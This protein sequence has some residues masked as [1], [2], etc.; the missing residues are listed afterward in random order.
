MLLHGVLNDHP[1][2]KY[3]ELETV[4]RVLSFFDAR[5]AFWSRRVFEPDS[6][7]YNV[8]PKF[9]ERFATFEKMIGWNGEAVKPVDSERFFGWYTS[10]VSGFVRP[11]PETTP[12]DV[13][14]A[15][16]QTSA[17]APTVSQLRLPNEMSWVV[18]ADR[19]V[20]LDRLVSLVEL[21]VNL[22]V[23]AKLLTENAYAAG[24][25]ELAD[26]IVELGRSDL[27][28][29]V[30]LSAS[31]VAVA[32]ERA[33]SLEQAFDIAD[34][35]V[36]VGRYLDA[37]GASS[38]PDEAKVDAAADEFRIEAF[39]HMVNAGVNRAEA[40]EVARTD[41][42]PASWVSARRHASLSDLAAV[43]VRD[44]DHLESYGLAREAGL[45]H[46]RCMQVL[47]ADLPLLEYVRL[48]NA[49]IEDHAQIITALLAQQS[50]RQLI[51]AVQEASSEQVRANQALAK[52][53][54]GALEELERGT[55]AIADATTRA[56]NAQ[57]EATRLAGRDIESAVRRAG[58]WQTS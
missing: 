15:L 26:A 22:D 4:R 11:G 49:G 1:F 6:G 24:T 53:L 2:I 30:G 12:I 33:V 41:V 3:S 17:V 48:R 8:R 34:R 58:W 45:E 18:P 5:I 35:G 29:V 19:Q 37:L 13:A 32:R 27:D 25:T 56:S 52:Q 46:S 39:D 28:K 43:A 7:P 21:H 40:Y 51:G 9:G 42:M 16:S 54:L 20:P 47:D 55:I 38:I 44:V 14:I 57:V 31:Q 36:N 10:K 23:V 50:N